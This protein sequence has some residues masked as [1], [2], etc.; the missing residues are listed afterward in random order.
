MLSSEFV[1]R[2]QCWTCFKPQPACIC[3]AI[4]PVEN[5]TGVT[6]LQHPRERFHV[7]GTARIAHL[8]LA[9]VRVESCAPWTDAAAIR[10]RLPP[11]AAVL[12]PSARARELSGLAAAEHP[13]HL[14]A[15]DAT[16]FLAKK[17]YDAHTW[18]HDLPHVR[19]TPSR[20]SRYGRVRREPRADYLATLEAVVEALRVLEPDTVGFDGLLGVF[21]QMVER[22]SRYMRPPVPGGGPEADTRRAPLPA[23]R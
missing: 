11:G 17:I 16:W 20:P 10:R 21:A 4:R 5:R 12:Y 13:P 23:A 1:P 7:V 19:L 18:L 6:I 14:V 8:G 22:Q 3:D 9:R 15:I 2:A